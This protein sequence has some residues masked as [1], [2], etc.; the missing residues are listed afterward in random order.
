MQPTAH[1]P[2]LT[3]LLSFVIGM[4]YGVF[5][6]MSIRSLDCN[7]PFLNEDSHQSRS[8]RVQVTIQGRLPIQMPETRRVIAITSIH[9]YA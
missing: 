4:E 9:P 7:L 5:R 1:G 6:N 8:Q 3:G 2:L